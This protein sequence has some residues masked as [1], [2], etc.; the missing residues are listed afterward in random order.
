[1]AK[2]FTLAELSELTEAILIGDPSHLI[3][4]VDGLVTASSDDASF[5]A[6]ARYAESML[7]SKAGVICVDHE[8]KLVDG[9]NFL[10]SDDPS[11]L[12]QKIAELC[13]G[14]IFL[15]TAFTGIHPNAVV[16]ESAQIA[17]TATIAPCAVIDQGS[18]IGEG[19]TIGSNV[20][21]GAGVV[22]GKEC[23]IHPNVTIRDGSIIGNRVILQPGVVV[24]SCGF[25]YL[26][27]E[28][29]K[30]QKLK[31]L[32]VVIIEDDVEIGANTTI[33]RARF[34]ATIIKR[35]TKIDNL[36]QIAH[37]VEIGEDNIIVSQTG[38]AGSTKTGRHVIIGGQCGLTGHIELAD[39]V[40]LATRSGVSKS[41][42]QPGPYRGSPAIP[43]ST[44]NKREV[45]LRNIEKLIRRI[46][47][48]EE[49]L[50]EKK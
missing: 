27:D 29:G 30:H 23:V 39:G 12:F 46:E 31:Q 11:Q 14:G 28:R 26:T 3:S 4:N 18:H 45:Q 5:L 42:K 21:I 37:N 22:I 33:D 19:T 44:Y 20:S 49:Q 25:G 43:L 16:H 17:D 6:N 7:T 24:G 8:T 50:A 13:L 1:M 36:V 40:Q 41:L 38:I 32:G 48:L 2:Q 47:A 15:P 10:I 34:K 35:G 9:K